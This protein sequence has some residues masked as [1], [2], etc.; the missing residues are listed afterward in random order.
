[1]TRT[2]ARGYILP[3]RLQ[4]ADELAEGNETVA[5][6]Y[7]RSKYEVYDFPAD[8]QELSAGQSSRTAKIRLEELQT[9]HGIAHGE[10]TAVGLSTGAKFKLEDYPREEYND[11]SL[12]IGT[13]YSLSSNPR[14][15][16]GG[17]AEFHVSVEAIHSRSSS[18][19][20]V[21][22]ADLGHATT[23]VVA[24][25]GKDRTAPTR[26]MANRRGQVRPG[27]REVP[28]GPP[29]HELVPRACGTGVGRQNWGAQYVPRIGHSIVSFLGRA[30]P[31]DHRRQCLQRRRHTPYATDERHAERH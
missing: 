29:G 17:T 11:D 22:E 2:A 23:I 30:G 15:S 1:M 5:R 10:G 12:V 8:L 21:A 28:L 3:F 26:A 9:T 20:R 25:T 13:S 16:S 14:D 18:D 6:Q 24:G 31:T 19:R 7:A 27:A 4:E